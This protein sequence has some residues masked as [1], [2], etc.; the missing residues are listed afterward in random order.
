[1][2]SD[3]QGRGGGRAYRFWCGIDGRRVARRWRSRNRGK[4]GD[5]VLDACADVGVIRIDLE[6]S[7]EFR[8]G[9]KP[10]ANLGGG[11]ATHIAHCQRFMGSS[12]CDVGCCLGVERGSGGEGVAGSRGVYVLRSNGGAGGA[13]GAGNCGR[14]CC[15][16]ALLALT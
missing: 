7:S 9:R 3:S 14:V 12:R 2:R 16:V 1:L 15:G 5:C 13:R 11:N 4:R 8:Q 6:N 10:I